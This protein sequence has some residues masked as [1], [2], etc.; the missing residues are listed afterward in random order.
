MK[1]FYRHI[2]NVNPH[3]YMHFSWL[4]RSLPGWEIFK[5]WSL[6]KVM[7]CLSPQQLCFPVSPKCFPSNSASGHRQQDQILSPWP[8]EWRRGSHSNL[9][10]IR[11]WVS[12]GPSPRVSM[13]KNL[14]STNSYSWNRY[15]PVLFYKYKIKQYILYIQICMCNLHTDM[16]V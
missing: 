3:F 4:L 14:C 7:G 9:K 2:Q 12:I 10:A 16:Y 13:L 5:N 1:Y 11:F 8:H 6:D 15:W